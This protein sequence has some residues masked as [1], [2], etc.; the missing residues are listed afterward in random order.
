MYTQDGRNSIDTK[1]SVKLKKVPKVLFNQSTSSV[2]S[3]Q[4]GLYT[5]EQGSNI[6]NQI[7]F[8]PYKKLG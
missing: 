5:I 4:Y 8:N 2:T 1:V 6:S 3:W 7:E